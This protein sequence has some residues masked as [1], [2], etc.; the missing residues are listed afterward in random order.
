M[1]CSL[2]D[3]IR[4]IYF[5]SSLRCLNSGYFKF[6]LQKKSLRNSRCI[7]HLTTKLIPSST[8][9]HTSYRLLHTGV[10][11]LV[12]LPRSISR[13]CELAL[14]LVIALLYRTSF[15]WSRYGSKPVSPDYWIFLHI[16]NFS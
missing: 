2:R 16:P 14:S 8:S 15:T 1:S 13:V 4:N 7:E 11:G 10:F 6:T 12:Y 5:S 3:V 9:R